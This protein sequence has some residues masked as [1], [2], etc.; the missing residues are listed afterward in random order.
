MSW[1]CSL[2]VYHLFCAPQASFCRSSEGGRL[3]GRGKVPPSQCSRPLMYAVCREDGQHFCRESFWLISWR[4]FT[5]NIHI[6]N[7]FEK[8]PYKKSGCAKYHN[9]CDYHDSEAGT[10][11]VCAV[12][13][14]EAMNGGPVCKPWGPCAVV[15]NSAIHL[16][17]DPTGHNCH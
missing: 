2:P 7:P 5:D 8:L 1:S 12:V 11:F 15:G 4:T 10:L 16:I 9:S 17:L 6:L 3:S 13:P 14:H